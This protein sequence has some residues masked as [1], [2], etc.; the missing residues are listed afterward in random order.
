MGK[1]RFGRDL[2]NSVNLI[3]ELVH[4]LLMHAQTLA[5]LLAALVAADFFIFTPTVTSNVVLEHRMSASAVDRAYT[6]AQLPEVVQDAV[7]DLVGRSDPIPQ[8]AASLNGGAATSTSSQVTAA[9][10]GAATAGG[11]LY[12][13]TELCAKSRAI[14]ETAF[15][16]ACTSQ[17]EIP[18]YD[19]VLLH[20]D[21]QVAQPLEPDALRAA[22]SNL[23]AAEYV[24]ATVTLSNPGKSTAQNVSVIA[25]SAFTNR[26]GTMSIPLGPGSSADFVYESDPG[27]AGA[28]ITSPTF[29]ARWDPIGPLDPRFQTQVVVV[30][31]LI[32]A[33]LAGLDLVRLIT[34]PGG[35]PAMAD[36]DPQT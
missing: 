21:E 9:A 26:F 34:R 20:W 1:R 8:A 28:A 35:A 24:R 14:V 23:A 33:L 12:P 10:G 30:F 3:N 31:L 7:N 22:I 29:T 6:N 5:I 13:L 17:L 16:G 15:A 19:R 36:A 18:W 4:D 32:L 11:R 27:A 2:I 25:P